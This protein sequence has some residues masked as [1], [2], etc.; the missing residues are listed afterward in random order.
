MQGMV[1]SG[2]LS[3]TLL[4]VLASTFATV[5]GQSTSTAQPG[6]VDILIHNLN[7]NALSSEEVEKL[8]ST[9][10]NLLASAVGVQ[11]DAIAGLDGTPSSLSLNAGNVKNEWQP[12]DWA[13][14]EEGKGTLASASLAL[15]SSTAFLAEQQLG[16]DAFAASVR[17]QVEDTIGTD[18]SAITGQITVK[19]AAVNQPAQNKI[20]NDGIEANETDGEQGKKYVLYAA[21][22]AGGVAA[23]CFVIC[24]IRS[25]MATSTR[26]NTAPSGFLEVNRYEDEVPIYEDPMKLFRGQGH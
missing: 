20:V 4:V 15:P 25:V 17:T 18:S 24:C 26:R 11:P 6:H 16:S 2:S 7:Y 5:T 3:A 1:S 8:S 22:V 13:S 10:A 19:S 21:I 23:V 14:E 12:S 9:L